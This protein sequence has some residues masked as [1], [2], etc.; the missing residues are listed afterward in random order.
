MERLVVSGVDGPLGMNLALALAERW[1]VLGLYDHVA[2]EAD[3]VQ[4]A[5][6]PTDAA[7]LTDL[8]RQHQPRWLI[9]CGPL[10]AAAWDSA[11]PRAP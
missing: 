6:R 1:H 7:E 11:L 5:A 3:G 10:A 2:V 4:C 9:H 8:L